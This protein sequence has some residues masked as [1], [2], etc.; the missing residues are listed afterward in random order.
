M[1]L[2][3]WLK[4]LGYKVEYGELVGNTT[5]KIYLQEDLEKTT[6]NDRIL[7][8]FYERYFFPLQD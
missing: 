6:D 2:C 5:L 1:Q 8:F 3:D 4:C 7:F